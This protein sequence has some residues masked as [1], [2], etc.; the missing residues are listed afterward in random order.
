[1]E[2]LKNSSYRTEIERSQLQTAKSKREEMM[3]AR[4]KKVREKKRQKMGLPPLQEEDDSKNKSE[5]P[6][7]EDLALE[8]IR[9]LRQAVENQA[10]KEI[11]RE[12][13]IGKEGVSATTATNQDE[14][15]DKLK[16]NLERKVLTQE[17]WVSDNFRDMFSICLDDSFHLDNIMYYVLTHL[18]KQYSYF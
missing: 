2:N 10:R 3:K 14:F 7:N 13:D 17:E 8:G 18:I 1:M 5:T 4:L 12:W 11:V 15:K 9:S 6:S 16:F